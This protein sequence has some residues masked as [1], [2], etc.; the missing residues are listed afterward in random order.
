MKVDKKPG[1]EGKEE[2]GDHFDTPTNIV[3]RGVFHTSHQ[4]RPGGILKKMKYGTRIGEKEYAKTKYW[5]DGIAEYLIK[6]HPN[7]K[8]FVCA[9]G[10]SPSGPIHFGN[11]REVVTSFAVFQALQN[12]GKEAVFIYSWD[13]FDRFRKIPKGLD[14]KYAEHIGKALADIP[15]PTN[16]DISYAKQHQ[17]EFEEA[18]EKFNIKPAYRYQQ[19]MYTNGVYDKHIIKALQKRKEIA[20]IML[21]H[22]TKKGK[23]SKG[24]V[25]SEYREKYFPISIYSSFT[26]KDATEICSYD[27][28]KTVRYRCKITKKEEEIDITKTR[29]V[30]LN[31]KID[32]AMR[33]KHEGVCFEPGGS[34]HAAP[35]GS[36]DVSSEIAK[37]IFDTEPPVFT[38]Y[39]FVGI[40]GASTKMSGSKGAT[41]TPKTLLTVY[42]PPILLWMYLRRIPS[43]T[44]S[45]A[46]N[47]EVYRQ[48][49]EMDKVFTKKH[50]NLFTKIFQRNKDAEEGVEKRIRETIKK[51]YANTIYSNPIPFRQLVGFAQIVQ[52]DEEK[53]NNLLT[54]SKQSFNQKSIHARLPRAKTWVTEYNAEALITLRTKPNTEAWKEMDKENKEYVQKV[55]QYIQ[56]HGTSNIQK[57]EEFLYTLPKI[58]HTHKEDLKKAQRTLFKNIYLLLIGKETGP[59]LSTFLWSIPKEHMLNLFNPTK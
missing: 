59:R 26:K 5:A 58:K 23:D 36:Y 13:N 17:Q 55:C 8:K 44:F 12:K 1:K 53:I 6:K 27:G 20:D 15:S 56:Q 37:K 11:F 19:E 14:T 54:A 10:I 34:D 40:Q 41:V 33:W 18:L 35:G 7:K 51:I 30:K 4:Q 47:T 48:Y 49:D 32:W 9:S 25:D 22:M 42:E 16:S 50:R 52:W 43:Q 24:I 57:T 28:N 29:I 3:C 39:G 45:I 21:S 38:E 2:G 46:L 31:W